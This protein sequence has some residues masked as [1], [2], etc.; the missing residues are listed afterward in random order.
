M[1]FGPSHAKTFEDDIERATIYSEEQIVHYKMY[2]DSIL[3][4]LQNLLHSC[5]G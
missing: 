3:T 4:Y 5:L 2:L 1:E